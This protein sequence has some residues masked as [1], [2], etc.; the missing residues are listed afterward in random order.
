MDLKYRKMYWFMRRYTDLIK[1]NKFI[2][3]KKI[4]KSI[5]TYLSVTSMAME[6][7]NLEIIHI[8]ENSKFYYTV[9]FTETI[10]NLSLVYIVI[11]NLR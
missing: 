10:F 7:H 4:I 8:M 6:P 1:H 11:Q 3:Y 9:Y 5:W 2:L